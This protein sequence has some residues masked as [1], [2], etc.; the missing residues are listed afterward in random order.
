MTIDILITMTDN[1]VTF[2]LSK[3]DNLTGITNIDKMWM[4]IING[5]IG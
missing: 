4:M 5:D 2:G 3:V 1:L